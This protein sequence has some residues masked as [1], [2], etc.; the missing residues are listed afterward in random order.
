MKAVWLT[1]IHLNFVHARDRA[2][3][4]EEIKLT[5]AEYIFITGDIAE[6]QNVCIFLK[7]MAESLSKTQHVYFVAGNHDYYNGS[8]AGMRKKLTE[9]DVPTLHYLPA[10]QLVCLEDQTFLVGVD[11]WADGRNGD[12]E[13]SEV[14]LNDSRL[15]AELFHAHLHKLYDKTKEL[16]QPLLKVM[17]ELADLDA[18]ILN[19]Q[20]IIATSGRAK[21]VI[22]LTHIPPFPEVSLYRD[23]IAD[24]SYLPFYTCK[25][26]GNVIM[27]FA[28]ANLAT[29]FLVLCGHSHHDALYKPLPN[30][31]VKCGGAEYYKPEIQDI[32][33]I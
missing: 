31:T 11:G 7:E 9:L 17:Q 12:Y 23:K 14:V 29:E 18:E 33:E 15:I 27:K 21:K 25:A 5:E 30:L 16:K 26:V 19:Q 20:L 3:F 32:F 6:A 4:Y 13:N 2:K 28:H 24:D 8:V 22:I 1:D 10:Y